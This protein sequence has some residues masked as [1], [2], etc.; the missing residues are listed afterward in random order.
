MPGRPPGLMPRG[1]GGLSQA[2]RTA[3]RHRPE[4]TETTWPAS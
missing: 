4:E 2:W 1:E 3:L